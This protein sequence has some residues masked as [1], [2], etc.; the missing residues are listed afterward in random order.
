VLTGQAPFRGESGEILRQ[1]QRGA[2]PPPRQVKKDVPA[3][4]EAVC[5]KAMALRPEQRYETALALAE[6]VEHWLADEPVSA[7][8]EPLA[9]KVGR[10]A[11]QHRPLV[12]GVAAALL[13]G[14]LALGVGGY[15]YSQEQ[16]RRALDAE[17]TEGEVKLALQ[18]ARAFRQKLQEQL[19][20]QARRWF[21]E[22]RQE[23]TLTDEHKQQTHDLKLRAGKLYV[24]DLQSETFSPSLRLD[25]AGGQVVG[26]SNGQRSETV[27]Y[28]QLLFIPKQDGSHRLTVAS[29]LNQG[30]GSYVLRIAE[31]D[32]S[33]TAPPAKQEKAPNGK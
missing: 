28:T 21:T 9:V 31:F 20:K 27:R 8:P 23:G 17:R 3:A 24:L 18:Q 11:R 7:W 32:A 14:L 26:R 6:D 4:L 13:V 15:W 5:L 1:V 19:D 22:Q 30:R 2:F 33:A 25:E 10:W 12:S 16:A 29:S